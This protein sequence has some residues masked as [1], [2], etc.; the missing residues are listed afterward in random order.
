MY[1]TDFDH[2][3][4]ATRDPKILRAKAEAWRDA[5]T[6]AERTQIFE[7]Y[8]VR[9]SE[10]WRLPY[11]NPSRML[12][13]DSMHCMLEGLVHYH[14]RHVLELSVEKAKQ[15]EK[16]EQAFTYPWPPYEEEA[17]SEIV[18]DDKFLLAE[19]E[20]KQVLALQE[21]LETALGGDGGISEDAMKKK[22]MG[23]NLPALRFICWSL[24]VLPPNADDRQKKPKKKDYA[25]NLMTWVSP[26]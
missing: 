4:W 8:G 21:V 6:L 9:W 20:V 22:L 17:Y 19:K 14:C 15:T 26:R 1:R 13:I 18:P 10:L 3:D 24:D 5:E 2:S 23:R 25:E 7:E 16:P 11:W 12:V